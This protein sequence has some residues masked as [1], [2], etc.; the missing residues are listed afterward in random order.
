MV[1]GL[2][3]IDGMSVYVASVNITNI[4][5]SGLLISVDNIVILG[6]V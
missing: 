4:F 1:C 2:H 6:D 3:Q 5:C